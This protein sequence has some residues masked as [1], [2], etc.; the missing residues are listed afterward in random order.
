MAEFYN[1]K[2]E[3]GNSSRGIRR[4]F[5]VA[6]LMISAAR[7]KRVQSV[8]NTAGQGQIKLGIVLDSLR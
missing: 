5:V 8:G 4:I 2:S 3:V 1:S 6:S 7:F